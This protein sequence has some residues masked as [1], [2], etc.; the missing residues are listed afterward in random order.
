MC[1]KNNE[2]Y[3]NI[4]S[5]LF[6][7]SDCN[8]GKIIGAGMMEEECGNCALKKNLSR[9]FSWAWKKFNIFLKWITNNSV[10]LL[11]L[12][13]FAV[14]LI[15]FFEVEKY[16]NLPHL[17]LKGLMLT[18][19]G[20]IF[21]ALKHKL[22]LAN[23]HKDLFEKRYKVFSKIDEILTDG[24]RGID[25]NNNNE[26]DWRSLKEKIDSVY[27]ESYF[28]FG[29]KTYCFI[30]KFYKAVIHS[31]YK[32]TPDTKAKLDADIFLCSL[33]DGQKLAENFPE[34]KIDSY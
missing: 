23:Y 17:I 5:L 14:L 13:L 20:M 2:L 27:R 24:F 7:C 15:Y 8:Q 28:L 18:S 30:D 21:P 29:E 26:V 34:L 3:K 33:L 16:P 32:T 9:W 31:K 4:K 10:Q 1:F 22:D 6:T 19:F 12:F 25:K 11:I